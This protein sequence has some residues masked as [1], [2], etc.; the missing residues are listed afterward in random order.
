MVVGIGEALKFISY[1]HEEPK[2]YLATLKLGEKTD[3]Q[4]NQGKIIETMPVPSLLQGDIQ[5]E[6]EKLCGK[7]EQIPPMFSAKK[8]QGKKLYEL[9][10][11]GKV[12]P[13][14]PISITIDKIELVEW[15][16]PHIRFLVSCSRGTYVRTLGETLAIN[17]GTTGH[18]TQLRRLKA[19]MFDVKESSNIISI[20]KALS[21][22]DSYELSQEEVNKLFKG[23]P[24]NC[25]KNFSQTPI[26][27]IFNQTF[28]GIGEYRNNQ[29]WPKRLIHQELIK[30]KFFSDGIKVSNVFVPIFCH[31]A[32]RFFL[33]HIFSDF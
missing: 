3:T 13:R 26:A 23:Q 28:L 10:R 33:N 4:D 16:A 11:Q 18:L 5:R 32:Q 17:L 7:Q 14:E 6:M 31:F 20:S 9:A 21:H 22:L 25:S 19:G 29:L 24:I 8:I 30:Q 1:L 27:F 15:N 2:V 12:I